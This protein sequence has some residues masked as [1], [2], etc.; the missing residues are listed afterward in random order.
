MFRGLNC[1]L[2]TRLQQINIEDTE[3]KIMCRLCDN[4]LRT[5]NVSETAMYS[6]DHII[7]VSI[8]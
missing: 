6:N 2:D 4:L 1:I 5:N 8:C 3:M 7:F